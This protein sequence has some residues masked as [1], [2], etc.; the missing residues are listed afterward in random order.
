MNPF[1]MTASYIDSISKGDIPLAITETCN[2][3]FNTIKTT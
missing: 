1:E 2:G 3:D